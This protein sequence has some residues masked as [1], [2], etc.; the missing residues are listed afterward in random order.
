[1]LYNGTWGGVCQP[2]SP[3]TLEVLCGQLGCGSRGQLQARSVP[4]T[5]PGALWLGSIQCRS[6]HETSLWQCP[7]DPWDPQSCSSLEEVWLVCAGEEGRCALSGARGRLPGTG[8]RNTAS[9]VPSVG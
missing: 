3:A 2:L 6:K 1:M 8:P 9:G 4:R 7:S 5:S